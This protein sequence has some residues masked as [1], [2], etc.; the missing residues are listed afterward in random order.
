MGHTCHN[1]IQ[2]QVHQSILLR[3]KPEY[4]LVSGLDGGANELEVRRGDGANAHR[5]CARQ[6]RK[7]GRL[8]GLEPGGLGRCETGIKRER[9]VDTAMRPA[10]ARMSTAQRPHAR[11][12]SSTTATCEAEQSAQRGT[13]MLTFGLLHVADAQ[14]EHIEDLLQQRQTRQHA[15]QV[16]HDSSEIQFVTM[17]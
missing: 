4:L 7:R 17:Q 8:R 12:A 15:A 3:N 11:H 16:L 1:T 5:R 10:T 13:A 9:S 6:G 2:Q 14:V